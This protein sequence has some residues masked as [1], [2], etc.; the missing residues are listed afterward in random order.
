[1]RVAYV[2]IDPGKSGFV[3]IFT[4]EFGYDFYQMP[5][6]KVETGALTKTGKPIMKEEFHN[7]GLITLAYQIKNKYP[8]HIFE[9]AIEDVGGRTGWSAQN[10][11]NFGHTAG[12]QEM[13]LHM[14]GSSVLKVRPQKWQ[15][16]MRQGYPNLKKASSTS[17]TQVNDPKAVAELIVTTEFPEID[18]RKT[19]RAKKNDDNKIDSFLI[20]TYLFRVLTQN[21]EQ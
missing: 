12:M 21:K 16:F 3:T 19:T 13:L 11:F 2:G 1:M 6:E 18:F 9:G 14:I 4:K 20:C 17:K 7:A 8:S 10:N 5:T 15:S